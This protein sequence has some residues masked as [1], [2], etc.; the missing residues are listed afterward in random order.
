MKPAALAVALAALTP[1]AARAG[2]VACWYER[3]VLVVPASIAGLAGDYILDTGAPV[4]QLHETK[5]QAAGL[6]E[7]QQRGVV[8]I[9]GVTL[10]DR[11]FAVADLDARTYAFDTPIA[12]VIGA[13]I[14]S[15]YI[16]DISFA[17]CRVS[18]HPARRAPRFAGRTIVRL[19][20]RGG[21][22]VARAAVSDGP[23]A[24]AGP[25]VISTGADA[26]VRIGQ[27]HASVPGAAKTEDL[28]PGGERRAGLRAASFAGQLFEN[29]DGGLAPAAVADG[30]IG[31]PLLAHWRL[32]FDF[33]RGRLLLAPAG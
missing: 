15:G 18:L 22:A 19:Q 1:A 14:L 5:A 31:A 6:T 26:A 30:V 21:P 9:A 23:R 11:A 29:L 16:V 2:E 24:L 12:G 7:P 17:P 13:D 3:G 4:T 10:P 25:F 32:R 33:P 8:R 28:L 27:D 20:D